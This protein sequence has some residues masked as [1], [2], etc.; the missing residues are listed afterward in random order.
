MD[1]LNLTREEILRL[2]TETLDSISEKI[3]GNLA[4]IGFILDE[5]KKLHELDCQIKRGAGV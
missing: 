2:A 5:G 4:N 1:K 3:G